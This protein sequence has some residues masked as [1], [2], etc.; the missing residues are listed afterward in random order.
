MTAFSQDSIAVVARPAVNKCYAMT[1]VALISSI[2]SPAAF[3]WWRPCPSEIRINDIFV[4]RLQRLASVFG[5]FESA[6]RN[7]GFIAARY[8]STDCA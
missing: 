7:R 3:R 8:V 6:L 1:A 4:R 2:N 5:K